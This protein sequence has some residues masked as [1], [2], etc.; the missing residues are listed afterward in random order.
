M[1][2]Y[3]QTRLTCEA[4]IILG[5]IPRLVEKNTPVSHKKQM[6]VSLSLPP[7]PL[8]HVNDCPVPRAPA[9]SSIG[10]RSSSGRGGHGAPARSSSSA[11]PPSSEPAGPTASD[12][13]AQTSASIC[14]CRAASPAGFGGERGAGEAERGGSAA[15]GG[16]R[17]GARL[18]PLL[19]LSLLSGESLA[20]ISRG[21]L[22]ANRSRCGGALSS[23]DPASLHRIAP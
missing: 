14:C 18:L 20:I 15:A 4:K 6:G 8:G 23:S 11:L 17:E 12:S 10:S 2:I 13:C 3:S 7:T 22:S 5:R 16:S 21:T 19:S 9:A 1:H